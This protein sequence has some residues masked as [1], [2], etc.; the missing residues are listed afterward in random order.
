MNQA[1]Q[2]L[3]SRGLRALGVATLMGLLLT[4]ETC[5]REHVES[6][7][8]MNEGVTLGQQK[9]FVAAIEK[10]E[11]AT[12]IDPSNHEAFWNLA[13]V[14]MDMQKYELARDDLQRAIA[15]APEAAHYQVKLG[16]VLVKLEDWNGAKQAL[17]KAIQVDSSLFKAYYSLGQIHEHLA[18]AEDGNENWQAALRRYTEAVQ[19]GPRF[20]EAYNELGGLYA[21]LGY[22]DQA[23]QVLQAGQQASL[24]GTEES[25]KTHH[26]LGSVFQEQGKIAEAI[27]EYDA[28]LGVVPGMPDALFSVGMAYYAQGDREQAK[29]FLKKFV[30]V[31]GANERADL[32]K[33]ARDRYSE[34]TEG[35]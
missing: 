1:K 14:H 28:A 30:D 32:V 23:V 15:L 2:K 9:Q 5:S 6:L 24:Q 7:N 19:K 13:M 29:R 18:I 11:R 17:E 25:A 27:R 31:A 8:Q 16:E 22:F 35:H 20:I 4:G 33:V 26:L 10:L 12:A 21:D 3:G 34:I